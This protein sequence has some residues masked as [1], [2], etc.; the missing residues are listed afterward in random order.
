M[1]RPATV[2]EVTAEPEEATIDGAGVGDDASAA[3]SGHFILLA[4]TP[5]SF[6][7]TARD[8]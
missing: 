7:S 4:A 1:V 3:F 8:L 2:E 5:L 6:I